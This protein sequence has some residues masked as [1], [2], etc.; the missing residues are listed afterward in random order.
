[1]AAE[2]SAWRLKRRHCKLEFPNEL[3]FVLIVSYTNQCAFSK[4]QFKQTT[5]CWDVWW[6]SKRE[7]LKMGSETHF[8]LPKIKEQSLETKNLALF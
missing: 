4:F 7:K 1:M 3:W 2:D 5:V 6:Q 8:F